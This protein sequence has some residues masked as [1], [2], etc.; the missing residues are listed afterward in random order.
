MTRRSPPPDFSHPG[1]SGYKR[2]P[3]DSRSSN[4]VLV[5]GL[6]A[7]AGAAILVVQY[8]RKKSIADARKLRESIA[9]DA[10]VIQ[11]ESRQA[12]QGESAPTFFKPQLPAIEKQQDEASVAKQMGLLEARSGFGIKN[13]PYFVDATG[14]RVIRVRIIAQPRCGA[15]DYEAIEGD[16][17]RNRFGALL[18]TLES[19]KADG[20][21]VVYDSK[22]VSLGSVYSGTTLQLAAPDR[23]GPVPASLYVCTDSGAKNCSSKTVVAI[24]SLLLTRYNTTDSPP[25]GT[26]KI[27]YQ[28]YVELG[29]DGVGVSS[30]IDPRAEGF[31]GQFADYGRKLAAVSGESPD[32]AFQKFAEHGRVLYSESLKAEDGGV[33]VVNLPRD[34]QSMCAAVE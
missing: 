7:A 4:R 27:Y 34:D 20:S 11:S 28:N 29:E 23:S 2:R 31:D 10:V 19:V 15:G 25:D 1:R 26:P 8:S 24:G 16:F 21:P 18:V 32:R 6:V 14:K 13:Q 3:E 17:E 30:D 33:I 9:Q 22:S 12:E 5:L